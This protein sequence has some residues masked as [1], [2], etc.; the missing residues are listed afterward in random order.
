MIKDFE[1]IREYALMKGN[2]L[3][4][5]IH[6]AGYRLEIDHILCFEAVGDPVFCPNEKRR[7]HHG[8]QDVSKGIKEKAD[9]ILLG[10][11]LADWARGCIEAE[12]LKRRLAQLQKGK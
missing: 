3:V 7:G 4:G 11:S 6:D 1:D 9:G 8:V 10:A 5:Y 12:D 2:V